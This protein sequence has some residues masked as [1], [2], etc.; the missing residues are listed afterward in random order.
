MMLRKQESN[1]FA[2]NASAKLYFQD[3]RRDYVNERDD[4]LQEEKEQLK[5]AC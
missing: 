2:S 4:E 3:Y 5:L 1:G